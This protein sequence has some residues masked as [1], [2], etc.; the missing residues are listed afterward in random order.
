LRGT[1]NDAG[2]YLIATDYIVNA[3]AKMHLVQAKDG[4]TGYAHWGMYH[5]ADLMLREQ[6]AR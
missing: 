3:C 2:E 4:D 6:F 1:Q 5:A